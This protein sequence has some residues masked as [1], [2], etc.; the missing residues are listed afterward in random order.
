L[1]LYEKQDKD[2]GYGVVG[3]KAPFI[4]QNRHSGRCGLVFE[5]TSPPGPTWPLLT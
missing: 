3:E 4:S 5:I 1:Q 2:D